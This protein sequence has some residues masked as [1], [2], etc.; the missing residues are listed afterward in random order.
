[1]SMLAF[2]CTC[3]LDSLCEY[4]CTRVVWWV[5][6]CVGGLVGLRACVC[7]CVSEPWHL[8]S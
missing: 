5:Y 3:Q 1:M 8:Q 6:V 2:A 4:V 7:V